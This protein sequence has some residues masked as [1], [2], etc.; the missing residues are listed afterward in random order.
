MQA[1]ACD[2]AG[3]WSAW[4]NPDNKRLQRGLKACAERLYSILCRQPAGPGARL[5]AARL[6][7]MHQDDFDRV[8]RPAKKRIRGRIRRLR[9]L[10]GARPEDGFHVPVLAGPKD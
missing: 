2:N 6:S 9:V 10:F 4:V 3:W 1:T 7:R 8:K 5:V